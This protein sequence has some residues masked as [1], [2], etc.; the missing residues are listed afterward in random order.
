MA[1]IEA[2]LFE[3]EDFLTKDLSLCQ[4]MKKSRPIQ[5]FTRNL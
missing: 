2:R 5:K 4:I 1:K 3:K